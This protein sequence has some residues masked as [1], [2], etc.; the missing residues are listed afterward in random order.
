[1]M[2]CTLGLVDVLGLPPTN[3]G[4]PNHPDSVVWSPPKGAA[5][6]RL[7]MFAF[8]NSYT[9]LPARFYERIAP[10]PVSAPRIVKVN[11]P[12]AELLGIDASQLAS[13]GAPW[14]SGNVVPPGAD[15]VALAYAGH[16]FGHFVPRL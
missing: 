4:H 11:G 15:T 2:L 14:L 8:D 13:S 10:T 5:S 3:W 16:Q 12:L 7:S 1:M 9:R 6:P